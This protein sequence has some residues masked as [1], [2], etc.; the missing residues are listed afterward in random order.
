[1][2]DNVLNKIFGNKNFNELDPIKRTKLFSLSLIDVS[3]LEVEGVVDI[4]KLE[5]DIIDFIKKNGTAKN[6]KRRQNEYIENTIN[7]KF[8]TGIVTSNLLANSLMKIYPDVEAE[9][10]LTTVSTKADLLIPTKKL[11]IDIKRIIGSGQIYQYIEGI[12]KKYISPTDEVQK[13]IILFI[14]PINQYT[15]PQNHFVYWAIDGYRSLFSALKNNKSIPAHVEIQIEDFGESV[16][17]LDELTKR[18]DK[19]IKEVVP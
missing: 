2:T 7:T 1:M 12:S 14:R 17:S 10:P 15:D 13:V 5:K 16:K 4:D 19:R 18:I 9:K 6:S 11:S 3:G 8:Y